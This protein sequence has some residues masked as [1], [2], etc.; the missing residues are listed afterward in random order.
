METESVPAAAK[1]GWLV[2]HPFW[3]IGAVL[4]ACL[5]PFLNQAIQTDD[6]LFVWTAQQIVKHP[7][8]FFG[9]SVNWWGST[10][11]MW[12]ADYNPP[13]W[14]YLLAGAGGLLG[15]QEVGLHLAGFAVAFAAAAGIYCL[16]RQWCERP[17]LAVMLVLVMPAFW[18]SSTTLMCDVTLLACW[19]W[20]VVWWERATA[21]EHSRWLYLAAGA[22][23]AMAVFAKYSALNTL[24]L[25]PLLCFTR[26]RNYGWKLAGLAVSGTLIAG[27]EWISGRM[28]GHGLLWLASQF[29]RT[30]HYDFPGGWSAKT[31]VGLAFLGGSLLPL[32][33]LAPWLWRRKLWLAG[34]ALGVGLLLWLWLGGTPG[35][36]HPW[37][38]TDESL[39][40]YWDF[41]LQLILLVLGGLLVPL[42]AGAECWQRRDRVTLALVWWLGSVFFFTVVLNWTV[43]VRSFLP[44]APAVAIL[45]VRRLSA[46]PAGG[47]RWLWLP[48]GVSALWALSVAVANWQL[49][50]SERTAMFKIAAK[51]QTPGHTL[52]LDGHSGG[53]YYL[54]RLG[55]RSVDL[56]HSLLLPGDVVA[57]PLQGDFVVLPP[58]SVS[59]LNDVVMRLHS[60]LNLQGRSA[61]AAAGFYTADDGPLPFAVGVPQAQEYFVVKVLSPVQY[62]SQPVNAREMLAGAVPSF[63]K[64]SYVVTNPPA[65]ADDPAA[66]AQIKAAGDLQM[67]GQE[68]AAIQRYQSALEIQANNPEALSRLAWLLATA[69]Q[70]DL[71]DTRKAVQLASQ[72]VKLTD[73]REAG[74]IVILAT[75]YAADGNR[76]KAE[77]TARIGRDL[78]LLTGQSALADSCARLI[79]ESAGR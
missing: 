77:F 65:V 3:V 52:W 23:A 21:S 14:P 79:G 34:S 24:T 1:A 45:V 37:V 26:G 76:A 17:L 13:L 32:L 5:G 49:A 43:N 39:T 18:V 61:R 59:P 33:L 48:L 74:M 50:N 11:P 22:M 6:T 63:P 73:S 8:D 12:L 68:A 67:D 19:V 9:F 55:G 2:R 7:L 30:T 28:Y 57:V 35:I 10:I 27:Y 31:L 62:Q 64:P 36:V 75:A 46:L 72:A 60:W 54:E 4:A 53:Q 20:A 56:E 38:A 51:H 66:K 78:A 41:R 58:G 40:R 69:R 15:W 44:A 25:L 70:P 71:R 16:A 42:L 29:A 47:R